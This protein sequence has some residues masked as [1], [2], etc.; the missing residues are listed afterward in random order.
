MPRRVGFG[1]CIATMIGLPLLAP[2]KH[3]DERQECLLLGVDRKGL[4]DGQRDAFGPTRKSDTKQRKDRLGSNGRTVDFVGLIDR[5]SWRR[6][7]TCI[8]L[9]RQP[10]PLLA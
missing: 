3:A 9:S 2:L 8:K 6:S 10:R 1:P 4:A 5:H 7:I